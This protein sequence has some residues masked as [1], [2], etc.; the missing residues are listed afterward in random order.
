MRV[1]GQRHS[2]TRSAPLCLTPTPPP[3]PSTTPPPL[4]FTS[5]PLSNTPGASNKSCARAH[6][7][8]RCGDVK[9][10]GRTSLRASLSVPL[11]T[12]EQRLSVHAF[13]CFVAQTFWLANEWVEVWAQFTGG[14]NET[15]TQTPTGRPGF[16]DKTGENKR[17]CGGGVSNTPSL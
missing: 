10:N 2:C 17:P 1:K 12:C 7:R 9:V 13:Q 3:P 5:H 8:T 14:H 11:T 16:C 6:A 4:A 15:G